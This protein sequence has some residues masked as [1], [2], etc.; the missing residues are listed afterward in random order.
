MQ[1]SKLEKKPTSLG[2]M[3]T[4]LYPAW[5]AGKMGQRPGSAKTD[6][7]PAPSKPGRNRRKG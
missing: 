2:L 1:W 5:K 4:A 6:E 7:R 3:L